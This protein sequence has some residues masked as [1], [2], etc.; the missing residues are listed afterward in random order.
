[1]ED[2]RDGQND[3]ASWNCGH[4]GSANSV[5]RRKCFAGPS[6]DPEIEELRWRQRANMLATLMLS[7]GVPM[8]SGGDEL[9]QTQQG[10]TAKARFV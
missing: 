7:L 5:Y 1:M 3:N 2:N 9:S 8:I 4:E 10:S 6:R